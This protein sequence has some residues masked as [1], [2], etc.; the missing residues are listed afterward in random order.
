[1]CSSG[2]HLKILVDNYCYCCIVH[3]IDPAVLYTHI[4][5]IVYHQIKTCRVKIDINM[6]NYHVPLLSIWY[7]VSLKRIWKKKEWR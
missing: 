1:M 5:S 2:L 4:G 7:T 6:M 3:L